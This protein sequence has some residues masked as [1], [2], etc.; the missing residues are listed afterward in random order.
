MSI[1]EQTRHKIMV[2]SAD[3]ID[4]N[5]DLDQSIVVKHWK[6]D[7]SNLDRGLATRRNRVHGD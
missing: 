6:A 1:D 2:A 4:L 3:A 5:N 7:D